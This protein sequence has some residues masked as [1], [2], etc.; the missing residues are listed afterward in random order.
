MKMDWPFPV[1]VEVGFKLDLWLI[2]HVEYYT[3]NRL[4]VIMPVED[5]RVQ[6]LIL[7]GNILG[8]S[9]YSKPQ[10]RASPSFINYYLI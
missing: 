4:G 5:A 2:F 3:H 7:V 8:E 1:I 10:F 6:P 9:I